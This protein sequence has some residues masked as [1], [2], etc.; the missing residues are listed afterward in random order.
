[1]QTKMTSTTPDAF[2]APLRDRAIRRLAEYARASQ[3]DATRRAHMGD[4]M[5]F[6][7]WA[8]SQVGAEVPGLPRMP[9]GASVDAL[10]ARERQVADIVAA[11]IP[12]SPGAVLGWVESLD[13]AGRAPSTIRRYVSSLAAV[14]RMMGHTSPV[15]DAVRRVLKG[16]QRMK[17]EQGWRVREA[18]PL[19]AADALRIVGAMDRKAPQGARDASVVL[20]GLATGMRRSELAAL[21]MGDVM[22]EERGYVLTIRRSKTDQVGEGR[23][24]TFTRGRRATCPVRALDAWLELAG[25]VEDGAPVWCQIGRWGDVRR[26][27]SISGKS[28]DGILRRAAVAAGYERGTF[29][30]HSLRAGHVTAR[31][32][33]GDSDSAIM[34]STGHRSTTMLRRYDRAAKRFRHDSTGSVGL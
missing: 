20:V 14:H 18:A 1:M 8:A 21:R 6:A 4:V 27:S 29:S 17:V 9:R 34:D 7:M 32:I 28:V 10:I 33:A 11:Y 25:E 13:A 23:E 3:A 22:R 30:A 16:H 19:L 24:V 5:R 15:D 26:Q 12:S 31:A 2:N